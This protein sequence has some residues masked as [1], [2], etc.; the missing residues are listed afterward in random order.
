MNIP[1]ACI[2]RPVMTTLIMAGL[3]L[4]GF[5]AYRVLPVAELPN[6]DFPTL[7][8]TARLPGGNPETMAASV[9][10]PLEKQ[11][12]RIAGVRAM[13]SV[14]S[15]GS[16]RII[17]EFE[18]ERNIDGAALDVQS[19][20]S[21]TMRQLPADIPEPPSFRKV[22][23]AD[24]P[25]Y[26]L[27]MKS[28]GLP[29]SKVNEFAENV[30]SPRLSTIEGVA[31]LTIWGAQKYAVR[32]QVNPDALVT[33]GIGIDEVERAVASSNSFK[34]TGTLNGTDKSISTRTTGQ[35]Q[36]AAG[37]NEQI[38]RYVNGAPVRVKDI[39]KAIDDVEDNKSSTWFGDVQG[40][41]LVI[42]R[43]PGSNT[44]E[45]ANQINKALPQLRAQE[46]VGLE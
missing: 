2:R 37:Y 43:Q 11:F 14:S 22:N 9:A 41:M 20:I 26:F 1:E 42:Y 6:V 36:T 3:L 5:F 44:V 35:I 16:T 28:L 12:S 10:T 33:R 38:I 18:L 8:V 40:L 30:I 32:I 15:E 25:I 13:T 31:Q 19:A 46:F 27:S 7:E 17:L 23:P 39:G 45:I 29:I 34:P 4:F 21:A 24:F